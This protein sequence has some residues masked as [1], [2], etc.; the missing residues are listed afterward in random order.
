MLVKQIQE[1]EKL[2]QQNYPEEALSRLEGIIKDVPKGQVYYL[3]LET[4][5]GCLLASNQN[6]KAYA[7]LQSHKSSLTQT[8]LKQ[9]QLA[10][11]KL[12]FW[13]ESLEYGKKVFSEEPDISS[14]ILSAFASAH[15]RREEEAINWLKAVKRMNK[16][17]LPSILSSEELDPIRH[18]SSFQEFLQGR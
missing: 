8:L 14:A 16:E 13:D 18:T 10:S 6:Q 9:M 11:F 2:W 17:A 12:G 4:L 5:V 1:A 15:L 7:L 3:A